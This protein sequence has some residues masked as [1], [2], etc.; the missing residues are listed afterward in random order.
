MQYE[1]LE[2]FEGLKIAF[3]MWESNWRPCNAARRYLYVHEHLQHQCYHYLILGWSMFYKIHKEDQDIMQEE[4]LYTFY[5]RIM[6]YLY[7]ISYT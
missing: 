7:K 2:D 4:L 6:G 1:I 3:T 5:M